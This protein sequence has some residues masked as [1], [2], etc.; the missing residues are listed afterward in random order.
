MKYVDKG[1]A[2]IPISKDTTK[3]EMNNL[4]A[5]HPNKTV[6]F[7]RSGEQDMKAILSKLIRAKLNP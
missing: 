2:Y 3:E 4:K 6:I 1:I 5:Q 7:L